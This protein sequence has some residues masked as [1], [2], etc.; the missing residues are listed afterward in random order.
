MSRKDDNIYIKMDNGR[1]RPY[2]VR[3]NEPYM[4]DGIWYV[5]HHENSVGTTNVDNYMEGL[6][7][8]G[9]RPEKID[10][11]KLCAMQDYV[12][13]VLN[14]KEIREMMDKGYYSWNEMVC[15]VVA[16]VVDKNEQ[17]K[18]EA[19]K[20]KKDNDYDDCGRF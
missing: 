20:K 7:R 16:L 4:Y 11:P 5:R 15:K 13:Y 8:V 19:K 10:V 12:D 17:Y 9:D 18:K 3:Y 14:S 1:Y 2:G 6:F